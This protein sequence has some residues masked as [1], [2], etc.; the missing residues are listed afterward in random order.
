MFPVL[1]IPSISLFGKYY[2]DK[3]L[4]Y[5]AFQE[6]LK[7]ELQV[8]EINVVKVLEV[9]SPVVFQ[10]KLWSLY[11]QRCARSLCLS[12][13]TNIEWY[14]LSPL[15]IWELFHLCGFNHPSFNH[16]FLRDWLGFTYLFLT[17]LVIVSTL[18]PWLKKK[19]RKQGK[20]LFF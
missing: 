17:L 12:P 10:K 8:K 2:C 1:Q 6:V 13:F 18:C 14:H 9:L 19:K 11:C 5:K 16:D 15:R 4:L 3:H 7:K 20:S